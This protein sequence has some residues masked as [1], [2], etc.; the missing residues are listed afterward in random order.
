MFGSGGRKKD[1]LSI[2]QLAR[3]AGV[4]VET[5]R[6][7]ERRGL[8]P[9]PARR[10]S[11][12]RPY[13]R[14]DATRIRFIKRA[15][16][17]GFSLAEIADLLSL[18]I[19]ADVA[20]DEVRAHAEEKMAEIDEKIRTLQQMRDTLKNLVVSCKA[21]APTGECPILEELDYAVEGGGGQR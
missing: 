11:G 21:R 4:H 2:G 10:A 9:K 20:C 3:C 1:F 16:E 13:S 5:V 19:D 15:Q 18:R 8:M 12:Y 6:Y 14:E 17:I 7:Y